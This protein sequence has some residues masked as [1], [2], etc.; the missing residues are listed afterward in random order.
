MKFVRFYWLV[1]CLLV[2]GAGCSNNP[3]VGPDDQYPPLITWSAP[4]ADTSFSTDTVTVVFTAA[5]DGG[6]V[7]SVEVYVG[8][9]LAATLTALPFR[10]TLNLA[11]LGNNRATRIYAKAYDPTGKVGST[12]D[13]LSFLKALPPDTATW[14]KLTPP[15][16]PLQRYGLSLSLDPTS[17]RA[18]LFGG[19]NVIPVGGHLNDAW[20][21]N[22]A[23]G[24]WDSLSAAGIVPDGRSEHAAGVVGDFL[25]VF[26]GEGGPG[27]TLMEDY[28]LLDLLTLD[29]DDLFSGMHPLPT[30]A[31]GATAYDE[32]LY[33]Y[34]GVV[35]SGVGIG[36]QSTSAF[37]RFSLADTTFSLLSTTGGGPSARCYTAMAPDYESGRLFLY[38]GKS[39]VLESEY[40]SNNSNYRLL[41]SALD[42]RST[43]APGPPPLEGAT[44]VYDS[45]NNRIIMWG[46]RDNNGA[47]PTDVWQFSLGGLRWTKVPTVGTPPTG[48]NLHG[49][50]ID[51]SRS[52]IIIYGGWVSGIGSSETWELKW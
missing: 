28:A 25:V 19:Y 45:L 37:W 47:Y 52:R 11:A 3:P 38:G 23:T 4:S 8:D 33:L 30:K 5:D 43:A 22:F 24:T 1:G 21:F 26:G 41:V 10:T 14:T 39:G 36:R 51:E 31:M 27:D 9:T 42:W 20:A 34:G 50:V 12:A 13:T 7:S 17:D 18:I 35:Y 48:R 46:G 16:S 49:M 44:T 6:T 2:V 32:D 29:W 40:P 15:T